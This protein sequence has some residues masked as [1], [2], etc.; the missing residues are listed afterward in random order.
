MI[1][2]HNALLMD[3]PGQDSTSVTEE[4]TRLAAQTV[5]NMTKKLGY[6]EH[7]AREVITFLMRSRY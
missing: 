4:G 2:M 6:C 3:N 1:K 7:C 5:E